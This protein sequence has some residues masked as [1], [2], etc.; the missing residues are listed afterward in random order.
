MRMGNGLLGS[1]KRYAVY[2]YVTLNFLLES[3]L[4]KISLASFAA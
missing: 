3:N 2:M 4:D 1:Q